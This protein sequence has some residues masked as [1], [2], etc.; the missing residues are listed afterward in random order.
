MRWSAVAV[1]LAS[2]NVASALD[3][4]L[5]PAP[6]VKRSS[7][8][9]DDASAVLS[10]HFNLESFEPVR[11]EV[12]RTQD[13][14]GEGEQNALLLTMEEEDAAAVLSDAKPSFRIPAPPVD[15]LYSVISTY[16]NRARHAFSSVFDGSD[17]PSW[18]KDG[19]SSLVEFTRSASAAGENFFAA[20][21]C[22][23]LRDIRHA[24]GKDSAEYAT[25]VAQIRDLLAGNHRI[26]VISFPRGSAS[27]LK[28]A[29]SPQ[30]SQ[31]PFPPSRPPPQSPIGSVSTC[32]ED[33]DVCSNSTDSCSGH[34]SCVQAS[35]TGRT[36]FVCACA[37]TK[38]G[39]GL[40]TKTEY[41][42][43]DSCE[44]KDVSSQFVLLAGTTVAIILLAA[45]SISLLYSVGDVELPS[46]LMGGVVNAKRD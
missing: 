24:H 16:L 22:T 26:A 2:L 41:W 18:T 46:V 10:R 34:G 28:R 45:G 13:F 37:A 31:S 21:E 38:T 4:Y 27:N 14:I 15:S 44:R 6:L 20:M 32:F 19:L 23:T 42:A 8:S 11:D 17:L 1:V 9:P 7:L 35:K 5:Y 43:G 30:E 40:Q 33:A 36:C 25:A 3:V 12:L 29:P 39:E